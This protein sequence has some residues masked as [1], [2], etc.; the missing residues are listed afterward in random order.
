[1]GDSCFA[2]TRVPVGLFSFTAFKSTSEKLNLLRAV[3][4][5]LRCL[6][7]AEIPN[8]LG[9]TSIFRL[10]EVSCPIKRYEEVASAKRYVMK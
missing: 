3:E 7:R 10:G 6:P 4:Q 2:V 9:L 1:M 8:T 5:S